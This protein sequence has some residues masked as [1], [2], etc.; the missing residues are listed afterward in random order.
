MVKDEVICFKQAD[1]DFRNDGRMTFHCSVEDPSADVDAP[2]RQSIEARLFCVFDGQDVETVPD[3][4]PYTSYED[5][6][7]MDQEKSKN[8]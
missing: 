2:V 6:K 3:K 7:V 5:S 8:V 1:S 4:C